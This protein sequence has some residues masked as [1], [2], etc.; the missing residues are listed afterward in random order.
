MEIG[1]LSEPFRCGN[2]NPTLVDTRYI[3]YYYYIGSHACHASI[4]F[5]SFLHATLEKKKGD[6]NSIIV[7]S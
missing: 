6:C 1:I 4:Y 2:S 3:L 5:F 7:G